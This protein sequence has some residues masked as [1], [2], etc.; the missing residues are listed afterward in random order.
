MVTFIK[1]TKFKS[2]IGS[3]LVSGLASQQLH[4][5]KVTENKITNEEIILKDLG[6]IRNV[7]QAPDFNL[8]VSVESPGRVYKLS[9]E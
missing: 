1:G 2:W 8:Y 9:P 3:L 5:C 4:L 6:R 7:I